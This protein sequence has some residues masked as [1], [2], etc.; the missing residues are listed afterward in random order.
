MTKL[1]TMAEY[2]KEASDFAYFGDNE[3][4]YVVH[5]THRDADLL[6]RA[7][8]QAIR[9]ALPEGSFAI[10]GF[11]HWLVGHGEWILVDPANA[12][13]V[14]IAQRILDDLEDYPVVDDEALSNL[15]WEDAF[16]SCKSALYKFPFDND[17]QKDDA[18]SKV[19]DY[20]MNVENGCTGDEF[21]PSDEAVFFGYLHFRRSLRRQVALSASIIEELD[22]E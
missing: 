10:E 15:E 21:W 3:S 12:E 9:D 16:D 22:A 1:R 18:A 14:E 11:G 20:A 2:A 17:I 7:N 6:N 13:A 5:T 8:H 19:L 4:W